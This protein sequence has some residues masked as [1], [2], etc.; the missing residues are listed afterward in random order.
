MTAHALVLWLKVFLAL[1]AVVTLFEAWF[2]LV[3]PR[4][5]AWAFDDPPQSFAPGAPGGFRL[6]PDVRATGR[7][8]GNTPRRS[9]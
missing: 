2:V 3:W 6:S 8:R 4:I 7:L 9:E 1:L 5:A